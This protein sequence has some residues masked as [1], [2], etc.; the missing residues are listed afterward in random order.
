MQKRGCPLSQEPRDAPNKID[1]AVTMVEFA[2]CTV[3]QVSHAPPSL[4][5]KKSLKS[6]YS[7]DCGSHSDAPHCLFFL[8]SIQSHYFG[9]LVREKFRQFR[10]LGDGFIIWV[11]HVCQVFICR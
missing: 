1:L 9:L 4:V 7:H 11:A 8:V 3:L 5:G 2:N 6:M 10:Q